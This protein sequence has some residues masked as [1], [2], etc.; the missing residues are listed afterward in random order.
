[1]HGCEYSGVKERNGKWTVPVGA[2]NYLGNSWANGCF[3]NRSL[4]PAIVP[5]YI[6]RRVVSV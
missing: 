4:I 6:I 5:L 3:K 1:M 2:N